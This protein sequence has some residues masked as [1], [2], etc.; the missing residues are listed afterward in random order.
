MPLAKIIRLE[1]YRGAPPAVQR[2]ASGS[3]CVIVQLF[4]ARPAPRPFSRFPRSR[5]DGD[6][7]AGRDR[8][9]G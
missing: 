5:T 6:R 7:V 4:R 2:A 1:D 8:D 3:P 9:P